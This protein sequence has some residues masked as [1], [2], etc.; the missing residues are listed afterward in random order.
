MWYSFSIYLVFFLL[1]IDHN[2][3]WITWMG[4]FSKIFEL[5]ISQ[6]SSKFTKGIKTAYFIYHGFLKMCGVVLF[7]IIFYCALLDIDYKT[8]SIS[9]IGVLIIIY[10]KYICQGSPKF[11]VGLK[12]AYFMY[13]G[14]LSMCGVVL[15]AIIFYCALLDIDHKTCSI[16]FIGVLIIIF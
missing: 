9:F 11:N 12:I 16:S 1:Y 13:H 10:L 6:G 4:V 14:C 7:T 2:A 5:R 15:F 3:C 8:C